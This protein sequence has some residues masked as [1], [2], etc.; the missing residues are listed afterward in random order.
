MAI[1][2]LSWNDASELIQL[3]EYMYANGAC[4]F[5][6]FL[7]S[8]TV[9]CIVALSELLGRYSW[10]LSDI[11]RSAAG[12]AYLMLNGAISLIAYLAAL[13]WKL[14]LGLEGRSEIWRVLL[15]SISAMAVIR[16]AF[17]NVKVDGKEVSAGFALIFDIFVRRSERVLDQELTEKMWLEITP[18]IKGMSY[19][20]THS[21]LMVLSKGALRSISKEEEEALEQALSKIDRLEVDDS[22]KMQLL[23]MLLVHKTSI[24]LFKTLA[25]QVKE[26]NLTENKL[27]KDSVAD[28][29]S[30]LKQLKEEFKA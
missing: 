24:S 5:L 9:G 13:D 10:S 21:H 2:S 23:A 28:K 29:L 27:A 30:K 19:K 1:G 12:R 20:E 4:W 14:G 11:L 17:L 26:Q 3:G 18:I 15:V 6:Y 16:S 8:F 22:T 25:A 7:I